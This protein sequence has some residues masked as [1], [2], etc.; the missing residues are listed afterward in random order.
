MNNDM[1]IDLLNNVIQFP[2]NIHLS[3]EEYDL[4]KI[5]DRNAIYIINNS[6]DG[7]VY[8]GERLIIRSSVSREY[9]LG[10]SPLRGEYILYVNEPGYTDNIIEIERFSNPSDALIILTQLNKI[11]DHNPV[12]TH[13][14]MTL[15]SYLKKDI[16]LVELLLGIISI[17]G[18]KDD[19]RFQDLVQI[20]MLDSYN[21]KN[22]SNDISFK[23]REELHTLKRKNIIFKFFSD[24]Y[25]LIAI[26]Y[27][28]LR[29]KEYT[30]DPDNVDLKDIINKI[31]SIFNS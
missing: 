12:S 19:T 14:Y 26:R 23:L 24:L 29:S 3:Q 27:T 15:L 7:R 22:N 8:H 6:T 4:I 13:V 31:K 25:D 17:Y 20:L 5:K 2:E 18:Y 10:T 30:N 11:G 21:H 28:Y 16:K 9:L 1:K